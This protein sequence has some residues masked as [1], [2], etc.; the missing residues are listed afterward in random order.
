MDIS[1]GSHCRGGVI[2]GVLLAPEQCTVA[3]LGLLVS[4]FTSPGRAAACTTGYNN[5]KEM[6]PIIS[7]RC[8][9][10]RKAGILVPVVGSV[11][12]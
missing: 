4:V 7:Y 11:A 5:N 10:K 3:R 9:A 8:R 12:S 6:E 2:S 1:A